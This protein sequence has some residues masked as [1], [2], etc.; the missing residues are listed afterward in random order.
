M[1]ELHV[2]TAAKHK[3]LAINIPVFA[4][5]DCFLVTLLFLLTS[6]QYLHCTLQ[7]RQSWNF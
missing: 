3:L 4:Y 6:A 5:V 7:L 1:A 2:L